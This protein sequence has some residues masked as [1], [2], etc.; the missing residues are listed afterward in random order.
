MP[1]S[2]PELQPNDR[3]TIRN[4]SDGN[5]TTVTVS[6]NGAGKLDYANQPFFI[7]TIGQIHWSGHSIILETQRDEPTVRKP[8]QD[9]SGRT[10][11]EQLTLHPDGTPKSVK[12]MLLSREDGQTFEDE[13]RSL[14]DNSRD[15]ASDFVA[16]VKGFFRW[17]PN[18]FPVIDTFDL[19]NDYRSDK[20]LGYKPQGINEVEKFRLMRTGSVVKIVDNGAGKPPR[21]FGRRYMTYFGA[22]LIIIPV[23]AI[24]SIAVSGL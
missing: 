21:R 18:Q 13:V 20:L 22:A 15:T 3:V 12:E 8:K 1:L 11:K 2:I 9:V 7:D 16:L 14:V 10:W 19:E 23:L 5:V 17:F 4:N 6:S 24:F